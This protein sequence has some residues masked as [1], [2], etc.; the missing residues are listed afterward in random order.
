MGRVLTRGGAGV[1]L[2]LACTPTESCACP[3]ARTSLLVW[4][5]S[6][7]RERRRPARGVPGVAAR[8]RRHRH[9]APLSRP[10]DVA[11]LLCRASDGS[12]RSPPAAYVS[13]RSPWALGPVQ[14]LKEA[15]LIP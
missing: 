13:V 4:R 10:P 6:R 12:G 8:Q 7:K 11:L 3:P 15:G 1:A 5:R 14:R 2:L 9:D